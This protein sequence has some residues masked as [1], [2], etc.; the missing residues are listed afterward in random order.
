[1][2]LYSNG[3]VLILLSVIVAL[4]FGLVYVMSFQKSLFCTI[5]ENRN[6]RQFSDLYGSSPQRRSS[7]LVHFVELNVSEDLY[8]FYSD[9]KPK[10]VRRYTIV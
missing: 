8:I 10:S 7:S 1:M 3:G 5:S 6:S 9:M 2:Y 4:L